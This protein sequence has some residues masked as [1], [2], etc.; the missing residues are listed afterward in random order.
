M[1]NPQRGQPSKFV[2]ARIDKN[3]NVGYV[4]SA[5][6]LIQ[7][8]NVVVTMTTKE[9]MDRAKARYKSREVRDYVDQEEIEQAQLT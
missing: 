3:G 9:T 8:D 6:N 4:D 5:G 2:Y 1:K 7:S